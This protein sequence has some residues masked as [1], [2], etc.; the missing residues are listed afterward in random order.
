MKQRRN[1]GQPPAAIR[2]WL[3]HTPVYAQHTPNV[4]S[5]ASNTTWQQQQQQQPFFRNAG[6]PTAAVNYNAVT[7]SPNPF[8]ATSVSSTPSGILARI[9]TA[10]AMPLPNKDSS[11]E[12]ASGHPKIRAGAPEDATVPPPKHPRLSIEER[13]TVCT[14]EIEMVVES[15]RSRPP[16]RL[17]ILEPS[18]NS[19]F[20]YRYKEKSDS[21]SGITT[22]RF[23]C[24]NQSTA[25]PCK[26]RIW[27][28]KG[29]VERNPIP[30]TCAKIKEE[31]QEIVDLRDYSR[32]FVQTAA[33][34]ALAKRPEE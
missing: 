29:V 11:V 26:A 23:S 21:K 33:L 7:F 10:T 12:I 28:T 30:H 24:V 32:E 5:S 17:S 25:A 20:D 9:P 14:T 34:A 19:K 2:P 6:T 18:L 22:W 8:L 27:V 31:P 4:A 3:L 1:Q 13:T 16:N 15:E